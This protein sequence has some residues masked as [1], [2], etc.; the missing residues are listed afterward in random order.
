M[1]DDSE[2]VALKREADRLAR[3]VEELRL[4]HFRIHG[5]RVKPG[6]PADGEAPVWNSDNKRYEFSVPVSSIAHADT[7]GKTP[8]DHHTEVH[9]HATH[10]GIGPNDHHPQS[11][12]V[13]SHPDTSATG[14]QLTTVTDGSEVDGLHS[15]PGTFYIPISSAGADSLVVQVT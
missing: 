4:D 13:A 1:P 11:H 8:D 15:H 5:L 12:P 6:T 10:S 3:L 14:A 9:P 7:T 2:V